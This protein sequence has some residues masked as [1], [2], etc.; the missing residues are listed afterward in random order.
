MTRDYIPPDRN[1]CDLDDCFAHSEQNDTCKLLKTNQV[2]HVGCPFYKPVPMKN[3]HKVITTKWF[4]N[5]VQRETK[6]YAK[7]RVASLKKETR[8]L[9]RKL[10]EK[11][12]KVKEAERYAISN[13]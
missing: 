11:E 2:I 1:K 12:D 13:N 9:K 6:K 5:M 4:E 3:G 8:Q 7:E 10:K